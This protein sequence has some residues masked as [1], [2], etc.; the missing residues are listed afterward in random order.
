MQRHDRVLPGED[1]DDD[2]DDDPTGHWPPLYRWL[3]GTILVCSAIH[4]HRPAGPELKSRSLWNF[5]VCML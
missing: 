1:D 3:S 5:T 2:D 4:T